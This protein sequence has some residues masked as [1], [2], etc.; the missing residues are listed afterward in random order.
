VSRV[1]VDTN[2]LISAFL[3]RASTPADALRLVLGEHRVVPSQWVLDELHEVVERKWPTRQP[4]LETFLGEI[5]YELAEPGAPSVPIS[6]PDD[7]PILDAA[8]AAAVD[9]IVTGD[10]HFLSLALDRPQVLTARQFLETYRAS[11]RQFEFWPDYG[12]RPLWTERGEAVD[13]D[14]IELPG[15]LREH[16]RIWNQS[17]DEGTIPVEGPGD[18]DW[19]R[20][21]AELL[22]QVRE[23]LG[24]D[25]QVVVTEPWWGDTSPT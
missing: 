1:L 19:L 6:D 21:G 24:S 10:E 22:R 20:E 5:D 16:L 18:P 2:V 12:A 7:Q 15:A 14:L 3:F 11:T 8:V 4:A 9:V 13:L 25:V 23:A 17:Y